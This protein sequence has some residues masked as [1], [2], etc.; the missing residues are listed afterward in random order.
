MN[1]DV[2]LPFH[3][4][5]D[6]LYSA[7]DSVSRSI[8]VQ[9]RLILIDDRKNPRPLTRLPANATIIR[10]PSIGYSGA[11][12]AAKH[13]ILSPFTAIMNSDDL[14][15]PERF[16]TQIQH[17][18]KNSSQLVACGIQKFHKGRFVSSKFG[19]LKSSGF[20]DSRVLLLGAYGVDAT[21]CG[22]SDWWISNI[23]FVNQPMSDWATGMKVSRTTD[24]Y[25]DHNKLYYYRQHPNQTTADASFSSIGLE[26]IM[27]YWLELAGEKDVQDLTSRE[28]AWVAA[29][30]GRTSLNRN[31]VRR[32]SEWLIRFNILTENKFANLIARRF[33]L[34]I[35]SNFVNKFEVKEVLLCASAALS[36]SAET[37]SNS[38]KSRKEFIN[39]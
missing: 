3:K 6:Y 5:D 26:E 10:T 32:I 30:R 14:V 12:N 18:E 21:W 17:L 1:I 15:H 11:L 39:Y 23:E 31:E 7:I 9:I 38:L 16:K 20:L 2:L 28:V 37:L 35:G 4:E 22:R 34:L 25:F 19:D 13:S 27:K 24:I 33:L 36:I 8:G 29:P